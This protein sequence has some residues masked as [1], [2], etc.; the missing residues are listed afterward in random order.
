MLA[1]RQMLSQT[2]EHFDEEF[3]GEKPNKQDLPES[4]IASGQVSVVT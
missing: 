4:Q 3:H 1:G 2:P